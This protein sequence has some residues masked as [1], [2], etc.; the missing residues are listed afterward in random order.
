MKKR[1]YR[2]RFD[3]KLAGIFGGLGQYFKV[4]ATLLRLI[5][6]LLLFLT[7]GIL[8]LAYLLL[9]AILPLGP[10]SY[11]EAHYKRLYRSRKDRRIAGICGGLGEYFNFDPNLIRLIVVVLLFITGIIPVFIAYLIGCI[12]IQDAPSSRLR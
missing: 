9:W 4:D 7:G 6:L 3:Y 2:D 5:G 1:L 12:I 10:R 8:S 11:V